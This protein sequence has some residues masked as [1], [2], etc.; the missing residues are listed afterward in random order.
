MANASYYSIRFRMKCLQKNGTV[1][2]CCQTVVSSNNC[3]KPQ[4]EPEI[5]KKTRDTH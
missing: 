3:K 1:Y 2:E 5:G 4:M